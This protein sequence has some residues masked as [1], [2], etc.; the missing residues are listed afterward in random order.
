MNR[1]QNLGFPENVFFFPRNMSQKCRFTV[2]FLF[3]FRHGKD[4]RLAFL[5]F[6]VLDARAMRRLA[7]AKEADGPTFV[8]PGIHLPE[9]QDSTRGLVVLNIG[10]MGKDGKI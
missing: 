10:G 3:I 9:V 6:N 7:L 4:G 8:I 1:I 5:A 2:A